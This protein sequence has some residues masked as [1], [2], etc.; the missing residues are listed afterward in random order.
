MENRQIIDN[1]IFVKEVICTR[2]SNK[3]RGMVI[4]LGMVNAFTRVKHA[5]L[6]SMLSKFVFSKDFIDWIQACIISPWID[7]LIN[8]RPSQ[9]FKLVEESD[10]VSPSLPPFILSWLKL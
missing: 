4:K 2:R 7:P 8:G 3:E 9:F 5:F 1:I 10:R 6:Y